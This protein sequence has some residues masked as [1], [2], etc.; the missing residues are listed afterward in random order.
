MAGCE[1]SGRVTGVGR[2]GRGC[3][4]LQPG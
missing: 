4:S 1:L 2:S 3:P